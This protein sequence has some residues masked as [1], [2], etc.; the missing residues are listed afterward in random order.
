MNKKKI[1][2]VVV[3]ENNIVVNPDLTFLKYHCNIHV[4]LVEGQ[5]VQ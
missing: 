4:V 1:S 2:L 3:N 5:S